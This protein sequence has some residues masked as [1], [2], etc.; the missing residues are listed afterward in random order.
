MVLCR[1][2]FSRHL[3]TADQLQAVALSR[4]CFAMCI[5]YYMLAEPACTAQEIWLRVPC[6]GM[7]ALART[8]HM[9]QSPYTTSKDLQQPQKS[10]TSLFDRA[11]AL[12]A[13]QIAQ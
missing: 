9:C 12:P 10:P 8:T 4:M 11:G 7:I 13:S 2:L 5:L 1:W 6:H 3:D